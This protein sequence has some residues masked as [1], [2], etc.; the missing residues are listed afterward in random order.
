MILIYSPAISPRLH[1]TLNVIFLQWL[2]VD[3]AVTAD[4]DEFCAYPGAKIAYAASCDGSQTVCL[5]KLSGILFEQTIEKQVVEV[6]RHQNI[7]VL[8]PCND[9]RLA[10]DLPFDI[11]SAVFYQLSRYEEYTNS[12][13]DTHG[14][15]PASASLAYQ[16]NFLSVPVVN[17]WIE[18]LKEKIRGKFP[19]IEFAVQKFQFIDTIDVDNAFA[20]KGKGWVRNI[21]GA[22][23]DRNNRQWLKKRIAVWLDH[24]PDPFDTFAW[25]IEHTRHKNISQ[26]VYFFLV[27]NYAAWDKNVPFDYP[28]LKKRIHFLQ[29][30]EVEIALHPSYAS[31]NEPALLQTEKER[32]E[33]LTGTEI[34]SARQHFLKLHLP[35]TYRNLLDIGIKNDYTLG[36][37]DAVGFRAGVCLPFIFFD[38]PGNKVTDLTLYPLTAMDATFRYY[39]K[40]TPRQAKEAYDKLL[41]EV[42][43]VNGTFVSLWH[44]DAL[45]NDENWV[46]WQ[47]V[48]RHLLNQ[49][50]L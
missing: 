17:Y 37:P 47:K 15:F 28:L 6:S 20:F 18:W 7:A 25:H 43:K 8:F 3:Y 14:R 41:E 12:A 39:L 29:K 24:R 5:P 4:K 22:I 23:R 16:H 1:Y 30:Y 44:N 9:D 33:Y 21:G 49:I 45:S 13:R 35:H 26:Q 32:L 48:Y 11:F 34:R 36:Y 42:K 2:R 10:Y 40:Y 50:D 46:G 19:H 38:L 31:N 27:G